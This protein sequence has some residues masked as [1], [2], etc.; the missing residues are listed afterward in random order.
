MGPTVPSEAFE[1]ICPEPQADLLSS[2]DVDP[3][4][5]DGA[6]PDLALR[7]HFTEQPYC[8]TMLTHDSYDSWV[9]C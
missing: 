1:I 5:A 7:G 3:Q 9:C 2:I 6:D 4:N 8:P